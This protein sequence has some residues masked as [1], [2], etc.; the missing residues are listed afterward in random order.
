MIWFL[1]LGIVLFIMFKVI[2][3]DRLE[4]FGEWLETPIDE[5]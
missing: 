5:L 3:I 1:L 4:K 2:K